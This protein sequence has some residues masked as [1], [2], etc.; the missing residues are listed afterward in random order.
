MNSPVLVGLY[1]AWGFAQ[2]AVGVLFISAY[3]A[4]RRDVEFLLFGALCFA[5]AGADFGF[6][7]MYQVDAGYEWNRAGNATNAAIALAIALGVH[8]SSSFVPSSRALRRR[9]GLVYLASIAFA[10]AALLDFWTVPGSLRVE[11]VSLFGLEVAQAYAEPTLIASTFYALSAPAYAWVVWVLFDATRRGRSET[12][13][14][15]LAM[16]LSSPLV[17]NDVLLSTFHL[18]TIYLTPIG[19][20]TYGLGF[21]FALLARYERAATDLE[22]T[23]SELRS[24]TDELTMS[25]GELS[26]VQEELFRRRQLASVGE[27]AG[28]IAHEVRNPLAIIRNAAA[29][30]RRRAANECDR[31]TL[32]A[33]VDEEIDRLNGLVTE[34]L[35]FARPVNVERSDVSVAE[36][37]EGIRKEVGPDHQL[38]LQVDEKCGES[39]WADPT[40]LRLVLDNLVANAVQAM[41]D[42]GEIVVRVDIATADGASV[43]RVDVIDAGP[44]MDETTRARAFDPFFTTRPKGTGLGLPIVRRIMEAHDGFAL[45]H[46]ER[47]RGTTVTLLLPQ[48]PDAGARISIVPP[49]R[50]A[51]T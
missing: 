7:R 42:G 15:F 29:S 28:T 8:F 12:R 45:I 6:A 10:G 49:E 9:V 44:G 41:P 20:L 5:L 39:V 19:F 13:G 48:K 3:V 25:Y 1:V 2:A 17:A 46:C 43:S 24:A 27:L 31:E 18:P 34:L 35:R 11:Q 30:L 26:T 33:I 40:L 38:T 22:L 36:V 50:R 37:V 21:A 16:A 14:V 32:L 51:W 47:G 23:A 4:R